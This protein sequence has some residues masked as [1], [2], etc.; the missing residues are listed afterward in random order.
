MSNNLLFESWHLLI[1]IYPY[2]CASGASRKIIFL[3][4]ET[5]ATNC[6]WTRN[7]CSPQSKKN[8][9]LI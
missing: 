8:R 6:V 7:F 4:V 3:D 1:E 9:N 2:I 5:I